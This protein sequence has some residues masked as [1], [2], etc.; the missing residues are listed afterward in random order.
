MSTRCWAQ[1]LA[2]VHTLLG[3]QARYCDRA[4]QCDKCFLLVAAS[5]LWPVARL[6]VTKIP[7][8]FHLTVWSVKNP[9]EELNVFPV[10]LSLWFWNTEMVML[11]VAPSFLSPSDMF[12]VSLSK[13]AEQCTQYSWNSIRNV[14]S[15]Q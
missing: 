12:S 9:N 6:Q 3:H 8:L 13:L 10:G 4:A 11:A 2:V 7:G 15:G 5:H 1:H 14:L